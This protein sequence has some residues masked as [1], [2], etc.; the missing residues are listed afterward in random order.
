[1]AR[2]QSLDE[3]VEETADG[4]QCEVQDMDN[5]EIRKSFIYIQLCG[6]L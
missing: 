5:K 4:D 3:S 2:D 6:Y 1:M